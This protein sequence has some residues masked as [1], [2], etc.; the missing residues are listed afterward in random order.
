VQNLR[1]SEVDMTKAIQTYII[2]LDKRPDRKA[3]VLNEFSRRDEFIVHIITAVENKIGSIGLWQ[4]IRNILQDTTNDAAEFIIICED[5][6]IFTSEYSRKLLS[7]SIAEAEE[8]N[9]DILLGGVSWFSNAIQVSPRLFWVEKFSGLQFSI[10]FKRFF[11]VMLAADF[12]ERDAADLKICS[13]TE[14]KFFIHP[15]MSIQREFGY[16]DATVNNNIEG[17]VS[18][19]FEVSNEKMRILRKATKYYINRKADSSIIDAKVIEKIKIPT[20][21]TDNPG[22]VSRETQIRKEFKSRKE[23][24][25]INSQTNRDGSKTSVLWS[26]I[27]D[28]VQQAVR[29]EDDVIIICKRGHVFTSWYSK[30]FLITQILKA[31]SLGCSILCGG[32]GDF[33]LMIPLTTHLYWIDAFQSAQFIVVFKRLFDIV[34]NEPFS[35]SDMFDCKLS[36]MTSHKMVIHPFISVGGKPAYSSINQGSHPNGG[37]NFFAKSSD[38]IENIRRISDKYKSQ[39]NKTIVCS[40]ND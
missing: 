4:S 33:N 22:S 23:F 10:I 5:D 8:K 19:L 37:A 36:E 29:N 35:D 16:S 6:H 21:I 24:D 17:R 28:A 9:A 39:N 18:T 15:F 3:H 20:Y 1:Q 26:S 27:I 14:N 38:R 34:L 40:R 2:N 12:N 30:Y 32:V 11:Q 13:L 25:I 7:L 31:H